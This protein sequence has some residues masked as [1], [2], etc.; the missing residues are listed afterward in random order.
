VIVTGPELITIS[1]LS[2]SLFFVCDKQHS[3]VLG[4][5]FCFFVF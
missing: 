5:L 1:V 4:W 3:K 2:I